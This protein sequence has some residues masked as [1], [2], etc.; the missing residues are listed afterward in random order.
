MLKNIQTRTDKNGT[1]VIVNRIVA[2]GMIPPIIH[3]VASMDQ[4]IAPPK[5][6][7]SGCLQKN[8]SIPLSSIKLS[9]SRTI[10]IGCSNSHAA[11]MMRALF[12]SPDSALAPG[13]ILRVHVQRFVIHYKCYF[14]DG[15]KRWL[16]NPHDA[17][18]RRHTGPSCALPFLHFLYNRFRCG[19]PNY[20]L[21]AMRP[22]F[23]CWK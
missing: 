8:G 17:R 16:G 1:G 7:P 15:G 9:D 6:L 11:G 14:L 2:P 19:Q 3:G 10:T 23:G 20:H 5:A 12:T 18:H 13:E 22:V 21:L 4:R